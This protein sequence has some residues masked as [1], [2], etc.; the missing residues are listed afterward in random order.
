MGLGF[1]Q[2]CTVRS[3]AEFQMC[4]SRPLRSSVFL[5]DGFSQDSGKL[6]GEILGMNPPMPPPHLCTCISPHLCEE[7]FLINAKFGSTAGVI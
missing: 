4:L 5:K 7:G 3:S 1:L 6:E 2:V